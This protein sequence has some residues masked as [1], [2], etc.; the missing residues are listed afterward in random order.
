MIDHDCPTGLRP[1]PSCI[2]SPG[3]RYVTCSPP[4][5]ADF[6]DAE[7]QGYIY[8]DDDGEMCGSSGKPPGRCTTCKGEICIRI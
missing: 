4:E 8:E 6:H 1:C 3:E 2:E 5:A 7:G